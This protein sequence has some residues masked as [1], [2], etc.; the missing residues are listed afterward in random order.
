MNDNQVPSPDFVGGV[1]PSDPSSARSLSTS[2]KREM[3]MRESASLADL[4][5]ARESAGSGGLAVYLHAF[6]RRWFAAIS[7]GVLGAAA[8]ATAA[9]V[10]AST[11]YTAT[12]LIRI[13]ADKPSLLFKVDDAHSTFDIY[14]STQMQLLTSDFVLNSALRK[15]ANVEMLKREEDPV[16]W[17]ARAL[18]TEAPGNA[19]ILHVSLSTPNRNDAAAIVN[20]VVGSYMTE[21]VDKERIDR[22]QRLEELVRIQGQKE[23]ELRTKRSDYK[24]LT[25]QVGTG[26]MG[27][28]SIKQQLAAQLYGETRTE[29][30]RLRSELQKARAALAAKQAKLKARRERPEDSV[31]VETAVANDPISLKIQ[32]DLEDLEDRLTEAKQVLKTGSST[33]K[34]IQDKYVLQRQSL[35][36]KLANRRRQLTDDLTKS[37]SGDGGSLESEIKEL[38][39]EVALLS[40]QEQLASKELARQQKQTEL[41]GTS[42]VDQEMLKA[43]IQSLEQLLN[44][45]GKERQELQIEQDSQ[46]RIKL[47]QSASPPVAP[48]ITSRLQNTITLGSLGFLAPIG[49]LLLWDVRGRRINSVNDVAEGLGL[50]V[51]GTVPHISP[52]SPAT[53]R[54]SRR[55]RQAQICLEHSIDGI[56]AKLFLRHETRGAR[57]VLVSS[58]TRGE[59]KS[60]LSIQLAKRLARTGA[61]TLLVDFDL[62]K[63]SLHHVFDAPRGPGLTEFLRGETD[64]SALLRPTGVDHLSILTAGSPFTDSLGKLSNGV[65]RSLFDKARDEFDFVIVDG[66][67]ILPVVDALLTSQHVDAVVLSVRRDVS[68]AHRVKAACDQLAAFG[69]EEYVAVLNG[70]HED[71]YYYGSDEL[72][73]VE[74]MA[75][76]R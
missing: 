15:V 64:L 41:L 20:A 27:T 56:A 21:V 31:D 75:R 7:L 26:D 17:L 59:G 76:P 73:S 65:T 61:R 63:P 1:P 39:A 58:A 35:E 12:A 4:G 72:F 42:S 32:Q 8:A 28:L 52:G 50:T 43:A 37:K 55:R 49:L 40:E 34:S 60:T 45:I 36:N 23:D 9:W 46:P 22:D 69:V 54:G 57:V 53:S 51:I 19:E 62:R 67:P 16:R 30:N 24:K 25:D 71:S 13:S 74:D 29:W 11:K 14:K 38:E 10:S 33:M 66:S 5:P 48:D 68:Q 18:Q 47:F 2:L 44:E 3:T 6:R 70:T